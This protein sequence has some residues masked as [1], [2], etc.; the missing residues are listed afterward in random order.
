MIVADDEVRAG[1]GHKHAAPHGAGAGAIPAF[2]R[3]P[4]RPTSGLTDACDKE[5]LMA[6]AYDEGDE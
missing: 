2:G 5:I 6:V 3:T 4:P 1:H